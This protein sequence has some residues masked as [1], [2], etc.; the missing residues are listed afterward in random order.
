MGLALA[1]SPVAGA[2]FTGGNRGV[3]RRW[4]FATRLLE[5]E[6]EGH[7]D[8]VECLAVDGNFLFSGSVDRNVIVWE[9]SLGYEVKRVMLH[10]AAV[11]AVCVVPDCGLV[12][13]CAFDGKVVFWNP[14]LGVR[15][16]REDEDDSSG[17][18][19]IKRYEQP[20]ENFRSLVLAPGCV[21]AGC[22]SG[23][24]VALPLPD[25]HEFR[26]AGWG[27]TLDEVETPSE[28]LE[29]EKRGQRMASLDAA[30]EQIQAEERVKREL[31]GGRHVDTGQTV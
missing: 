16:R 26:A 19:E 28:S 6:Y 15:Q 8:A 10:A 27:S 13:S 23:R 7:E 14:Q 12:V 3:V 29:G 2:V 17:C 9:T 31:K 18:R 24:I 5:A 11:Q 30:L 21:L 4:S 22:E 1:H 20:G 25:E